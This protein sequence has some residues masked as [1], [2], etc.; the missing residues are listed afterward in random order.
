M[1]RPFVLVVALV[2]ACAT[3]A[4][5]AP[6]HRGLQPPKHGDQRENRP[7]DNRQERRQWVKWWA[8][9]KERAELGITDHQSSRIEQIFQST[10]PAQRERWRELEKLDK[11]LAQMIKD[12]TA[13]VATVTALV[14]RVEDLRAEM[15]KTRTVMLYRI[16]LELS[17]DQ[18]VRLKAME[19][20]R[21]AERRKSPSPDPTRR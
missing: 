19:D 9:P 13:D 18:R 8:E 2:L 7:A 17:A 3:T 16:H 20:R 5:A 14:N 15:A 1:A 6:G 4:T 11:A 12:G 10:L 21:A